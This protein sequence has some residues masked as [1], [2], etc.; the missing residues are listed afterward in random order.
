MNK[1]LIFK[2]KIN[3]LFSKLNIVYGIDKNS[4]YKLANP[5]TIPLPFTDNWNTMEV[6]PTYDPGPSTLSGGG[7]FCFGLNNNIN[8]QIGQ[9]SLQENN[10]PGSDNYRVFVLFFFIF[11]IKFYF[12]SV[13]LILILFFK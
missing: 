7:M 6:E 4:E 10:T 9:L 1:Y 11:F 8:N 3:N 12:T 2:K 5:P 13:L